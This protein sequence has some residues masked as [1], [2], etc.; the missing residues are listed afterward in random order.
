MSWLEL[1]R[2]PNFSSVPGDPLAGFALASM[3]QAEVQWL[4]VVPVVFVSLLLYA[5]GMIWNDV[6]DY[7]ED[8]QDRPQRPLPSGR[9][10][11]GSAVVAG[12]VMAVAAVALAA[13]SGA[14]SFA[15]AVVL[16]G[17]IVTY[18]F[19]RN[20]D[21]VWRRWVGFFNMGACRGVS[22]LLG[23]A[24]ALPPAEW[25]AVVIA[26]AV[27][28]GLY[29]VFVSAVAVDEV[30]QSFLSQ[31]VGLL[32]RFLIVIQ[33]GLCMFA[34]GGGV[35]IAAVVLAG[36]PLAGWLGRRFYAS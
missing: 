19:G 9:I 27:G 13:A 33:A 18:D 21:V 7:R 30:K 34:G 16:F 14:W 31:H 35:W 26:A 20:G 17:L 15:V 8:L 28:I 32:I 25:S 4:R 29:I 2:V 24:A 5:A 6:A 11:R 12:G 36:W 10:G 3:G 23:A 22:L 1:M